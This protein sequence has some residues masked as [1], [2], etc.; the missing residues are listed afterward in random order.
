MIERS[1]PNGVAGMAHRFDLQL[2]LNILH[3]DFDIPIQAPKMFSEVCFACVDGGIGRFDR[4][5]LSQQTLME[6]FLFGLENSDEICGNRDAPDEMCEWNGVTCSNGEVERINWSYDHNFDAGTLRFEVL[7]ESLKEIDMTKCAI[8]GTIDLGEL[9]ESIEYLS[10]YINHLSG[11]LNL[12]SVPTAMR[13]LILAKN[14]F[15]GE[16]SLECLPQG[17]RNVSVGAN[18]LIGTI[19]LTSLPPMLENLFLAENRFTG[20]LDLT[21]LPASLENIQLSGNMFSG[22][23]DVIQLPKNLQVVNVED[24]NLTGTVQMPHEILFAFSGNE[25]LIAKW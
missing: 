3:C 5:T 8:A 19:C 13:D 21:R 2:L 18:Q 22:T 16:I 17:I 15:S 11:S 12:A 23:V 24:N 14:R 7:P 20:T 25:D 4:S 9:P 6:L 10:L 1:G